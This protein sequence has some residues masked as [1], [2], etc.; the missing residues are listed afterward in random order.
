[1]ATVPLSGTNIRLLS[2][3]PFSNDY[4][5]T[6]W[7]DNLSSQTAYFLSKTLVHSISQANYQRV[8]GHTFIA[9]NENIDDLWSVNYLMFQNASYNNKW[10]Y[11]FVTK[12]EYVNNRVTNVHFQIDVFQTWKFEM[13]F[14]PSYVVREHCPLWNS[15]GTPVINTV[16]EGLSYGSNYDV[17]DVLN[18]KPYTDIMFLVIVAKQ[19][20]HYETTQEIEPNLNGL[21]QPLC[22][23][24]HPFRLDGSEVGV[25]IGSEEGVG[26][27]PVLEVLKG[28]YKNTDA[29]NNIVSLYVTDH[30]GGNVT[31][32]AGFNMVTFPS[33]NF[34]QALI[35]DG[36]TNFSTVF[37]KSLPSYTVKTT[38]YT[39]KYSSYRSVKESKLLMYPY[40][41]LTLDDLKGNRQTIKNE[42]IKSNDIEISVRGSLG[43][44]NKVV[45]TIDNYL[46][47]SDLGIA[48]QLPANLENSVISNNPNDLPI[49]TDLLSAYLQGN[50]NSL[51]VQKNSVIFNGAMT[52]VN[53]A[54]GLGSSIA[55]R[56]I[57]G[58]ATSISHGVQG[59]GNTVLQ[60][61]AINA[62]QQDINNTPPSLAKMGS[63]TSFDYGNGL[64]GL[65]LIKKQIMPEYQKKLED[66][67]N[68]FG[69]KKNEVKQPNFHTRKYWNY[70]QTSSCIITG[71]FNNEDLNELKAIFDNGVTLWH[72][73]DVGNYSLENEVI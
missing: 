38:K 70:V 3:V 71:N 10:F 45:Y 20:M 2:G 48:D 1:M 60:L 26:V 67:F 23:Y 53:S 19:T 28:I 64:W 44:S 25:S 34:I 30:I 12:L 21:P 43:S 17:V 49:I 39:N 66:F 27:N 69:Y 50:R 46:I 16:D 6:R 29:V 35:H 62:K 13:N 68:M 61:Q 55:Q 36:E 15:D 7:F 42:Y 59:A 72:T 33:N 9:V 54:I 5:N 24:V 40:T 41:V 14:K 52:G 31:Y 51:E 63:N 47:K 4:K 8:E 37:A 73:D 11:A 58:A 57:A 32:D 18:Y 56:N 65:F 22:Y